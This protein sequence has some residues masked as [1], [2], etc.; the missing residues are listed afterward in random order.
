LLDVEE[1]L[2]GETIPV[3]RLLE[4][5]QRQLEAF[6]GPVHAVIGFWDFPIS[7]MVPL[8]CRRLGLRSASLESV[9]RCEHKYWSRLE[10][11]R[12]IDEYP[13]FGLVDLDEP[14][15]P[16]GLRYP[17]W[18]KP[19][20]SA[21]SELAYRV[22]D[23][24]R[25]R[26]AAAAIRE[27]IRRMGDPFEFVL[28]Q[29]DLPP[30]IAEA[31]G[32]ACLAEEEVTGAQVTVEGYGFHGNVHVYGIVDSITSPDSPSFLRYQYP[33]AIPATVADRLI[34]LSRRVVR[35]VGLDGTTFNIEYFWG[36]EPDGIF[37]P[38]VNPRHSQSHAELFEQVDGIPNHHCML[39]LALGREPRLPYREGPYPM[40]AKWFLRRSDDGVAR[41]VP[42][43]E[44]I[45][46]VQRDVPGCTVA[47]PVQLGDRL[48]ELHVQ[49]SYTYAIANVYVGA[50]S[51]AELIEK[52][53]RAVAG[54]PFEFEE[55]G[56]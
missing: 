30:E 55:P 47:V 51:E 56:T 52:Y 43:A 29:I 49:D 46:Q 18:L 13:P 8:L 2:F 35:Q 17:V 5:A 42:T 31:G 16:D 26:D 28:D 20:K 53:E 12:V 39:Q 19:V 25:L 48:S 15:L 41:R 44:E 40:A 45:E 1:M 27:G 34:D 23:P 9:V 6:D 24:G 54:L 50:D 21:A 4:E 10:Q 14:A 11:Q 38:E 3:P 37:L 7:T 36:A 22:E 33:S 32:S